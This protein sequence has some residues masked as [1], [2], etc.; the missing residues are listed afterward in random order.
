MFSTTYF[1]LGI[2]IYMVASLLE[3]SNWGGTDATSLKKG[4]DSIFQTGHFEMTPDGYKTKLVGVTA[5]GASVNFG[6]NNGLLTKLSTDRD[7]LLKIHCTN[8]RIELAVKYAIKETA[9]AHVDVF[10]N[11]LFF[12]LKNS[13]KT[14]GEIK[15][16][17]KALNIQNYILPKLTGTRFVGHRRNAHTK[18]LKMWPA[19]TTALENVVSDPTTCAETKAKVTGFLKNL[20]SYRFLSL[21]CTYVDILELITPI[22][23]VF[24]GEGL[25]VSEVKPTLTETLINIEEEMETAGTDDEL[26]SSHLASFKVQ[27]DETIQSSFIKS[28]DSSR[29]NKD[30]EKID[31]Q[32]SGMKFSEAHRIS[33]S[34]KKSEALG[35]LKELLNERFSCMKTQ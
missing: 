30:K 22:S 29:S 14:K 23:K 33:A 17:A 1:D 3:M 32:L 24:E 25:L 18:L 28:D 34:S 26:L 16:A 10:Y 8:H 35:R 9:F 20:H 21:V 11:S 2:P 19:I 12:F 15:E 6:K 5:D 7:W 27:A 13:G 31:L 4:I